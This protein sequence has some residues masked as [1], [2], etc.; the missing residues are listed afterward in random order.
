MSD[1]PDRA[2]V[3]PAAPASSPQEV[4]EVLCREVGAAHP[5]GALRQIRTM[6][7]LLR[8]H[9]RV[10]QRLER[11]GVDSL[12]D[13]VA[14]IAELRRQV[15]RYREEQREHALDRMDVLDDLMEAVDAMQRRLRS[16]PA[17]PDASDTAEA[18]S[19][20][21]LPNAEALIDG[22]EQALDEMRLELW[23]H[24]SHDEEA[25]AT[26]VASTAADLLDR[27]GDEVDAAAQAH[28]RLRTENERLSARNEALRRD[29]DRLEQTVEQKEARIE[30]LERQ[31][32]RRGPYADA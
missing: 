8:S 14:H 10:K 21:P 24:Q 1:E 7:R 23:L 25:L 19:D 31:L 28:E 30:E 15:R 3:L 9:Y 11:Y 22:L 13:A 5:D 12:S 16:R 6:K 2:T 26:P 32:E 20:T 17:P 27:L 4:T 29:V 18:S